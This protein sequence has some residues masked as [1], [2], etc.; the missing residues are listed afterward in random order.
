VT[1]VSVQQISRDTPGIKAKTA[2]K[3]TTS[4]TLVSQV[5]RRFNQVVLGFVP[6][7]VLVAFGDC[8]QILNIWFQMEGEDLVEIAANV[9]FVSRG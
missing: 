9:E 4:R 5:P 1:L 8:M 2:R 7:A 6:L 3:A